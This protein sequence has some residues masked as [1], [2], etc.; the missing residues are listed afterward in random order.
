MCLA[1]SG[2]TAPLGGVPDVF[3]KDAISEYIP[4]CT[5]SIRHASYFLWCTETKSD[6]WT[7]SAVT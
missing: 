7:L 4:S 6:P 3:I 5:G 2:H 1:L